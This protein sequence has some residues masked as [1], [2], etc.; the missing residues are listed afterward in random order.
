MVVV[1]EALRGGYEGAAEEEEAAGGHAHLREQES[2]TR[3]KQ[4]HPWQVGPAYTAKQT[5]MTSTKTMARKTDVAYAMNT[6]RMTNTL[7]TARTMK[8]V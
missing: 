5:C 2:T 8:K 6:A 4:T 7:Y 3:C 1:S